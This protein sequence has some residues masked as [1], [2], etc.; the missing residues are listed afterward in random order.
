M[1]ET[2]L[3]SVDTPY[4][5]PLPVKAWLLG[6]PERKSLAVM[7]AL[8]GNEIQQMYICGKL[9]QALE[10]LERQNLLDA[11]CGIMV[12]PCANQFSMNVGRRF[13]A[14][15]NTDINRMFPG[16]DGGE[17]TQRIA[18]RIFNALQGYTY[19][20]QMA[21]FYLPGDFL[22]H[23]RMM[24]T[25]YERAEEATAF[26]LPYIILRTPQPYD[27]TTL[28][29]NWQIWDTM[30]FSLYTRETD[31]VDPY[32]AQ[33]AVDAVL[34]FLREKGLSHQSNTA[35]GTVPRLFKE[36]GLHT[37]LSTAGGLFLRRHEPGDIVGEGDMLAEIIDPCCGKVLARLHADCDG[38]V[39]FAHKTQLIAGHEVVFRIL[40]CGQYT[41]E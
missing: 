4:R 17:T 28:N 5:Q 27:T 38:Q 33:Q 12:I 25:G 22:P 11:D 6:N 15:D 2:V 36:N 8:R 9:I 13:W 29:Y 26:G 19:G 37:V 32:T 7:G 34:R 39:F 41:E 3:F 18:A 1:K 10:R 35:P 16:Y 20:V 21:S 31:C 24:E 14:A 40:P 30:A 23:V